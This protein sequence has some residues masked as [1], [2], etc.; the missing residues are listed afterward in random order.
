MTRKATPTQSAA[1]SMT[2]TRSSAPPRRDRAS[3][4]HPRRISCIMLRP[5][6]EGM[7]FSGRARCI[8]S[9]EKSCARTAGR[10]R[11]TLR[12]GGDDFYPGQE[13]RSWPPLCCVSHCPTATPS[14][15]R[16]GIWMCEG[17]VLM[18]KGGEYDEITTWESL[19]ANRQMTRSRHPE[20]LRPI[21][22]SFV[23]ARRKPG[24]ATAIMSS[25]H[26]GTPI[27]RRTTWL[28][29]SRHGY[30]PI[31]LKEP[32][33]DR[34]T[35]LL[36]YITTERHQQMERRTYDGSGSGSPKFLS[37]PD[38]FPDPK[39]TVD[40]SY[41]SAVPFRRRLAFFQKR[42]HRLASESVG[43]SPR[44]RISAAQNFPHPQ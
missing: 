3:K 8:D 36:S 21:W 42:A 27:L 39:G 30:G 29:R 43:T 41:R 44:V 35:I 25:E 34:S 16:R 17:C 32:P 15:W 37:L 18:E 20:L 31:V 14:G 19:M 24:S 7:R 23:C 11:S 12:D 28:L 13:A 10:D 1:A 4:L 9:C 33:C 5:F 22:Q 6:N 26:N 40:I 2:S 38:R